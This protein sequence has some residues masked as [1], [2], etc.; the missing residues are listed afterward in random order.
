MNTSRRLWRES[1]AK[2]R[3]SRTNE[4]EG[5]PTTPVISTCARARPENIATSAHRTRNSGTLFMATS[6]ARIDHILQIQQSPP[7]KRS[8]ALLQSEEAEKPRCRS[9]AHR[10]PYAP[11]ADHLPLDQEARFAPSRPE[12]RCGQER[13]P[14]GFPSPA[15]VVPLSP[16]GEQDRRDHTPWFLLPAN[17]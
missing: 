15:A 16:S 14:A 9:R 10:T 3:A 11:R 17:R 5:S 2:L 7:G 12:L 6:I 8:L 1:S 13:S 4:R